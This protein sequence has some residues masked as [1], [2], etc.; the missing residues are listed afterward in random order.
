MN[1]QQFIEDTDREQIVEMLTTSTFGEPPTIDEQA[2]RIY[3]LIRIRLHALL[4][5]VVREI[6][7]RKWE[8]KNGYIVIDEINEAHNQALSSLA[9]H[10]REGISKTTECCDGECNH[11][12]CC[13]KIPENCTHVSQSVEGWEK[14]F[15][16]K[17]KDGVPPM[18]IHNSG[19]KK[20]WI[21][22]PEIKSFISTTL[23]TLVKEME[24]LK[25]KSPEQASL[26]PWK[27]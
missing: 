24:E 18:K 7:K 26:P 6:E 14:E 23:S 20:S 1:L 21:E 8:A 13:G 22:H 3:K 17:F 10:L 12:D 11:D 5:G 9:S 4:E 16:E 2:D 15:D 27:R 19:T 25:K